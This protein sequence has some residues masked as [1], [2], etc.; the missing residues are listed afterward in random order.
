MGEAGDQCTVCFTGT[1]QL[2]EGM[3]VCD[4]CGSVFQVRP[5]ALP[6]HCAMLCCTALSCRMCREGMGMA[7]CHQRAAASLAP[8]AQGFAEETQE[9]QTGIS[10]AK[11]FRQA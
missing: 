2:H 4:V 11:Y 9:Y 7:F 1:L 5:A 6:L 8:G 10:D 3:L